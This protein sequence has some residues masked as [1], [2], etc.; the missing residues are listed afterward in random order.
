[1]HRI[2]NDAQLYLQKNS[3]ESPQP[4]HQQQTRRTGDLGLKSNDSLLFI[5]RHGTSEEYNAPRSDLLPSES[6]TESTPTNSPT[7]SMLATEDPESSVKKMCSSFG[8][9]SP[10]LFVSS[11]QQESEEDIEELLR[12]LHTSTNLPFEENTLCLDPDIIDLTIIPPPSDD[13]VD[14]CCVTPD[15]V[16]DRKSFL[17]QETGQRRDFYA[18]ELTDTY[19][20]EPEENGIVFTAEPEAPADSD[21]A[22]NDALSTGEDDLSAYIIPPPPP[23]STR[24]VEEQN[25]VLARFRQAAEEIRRMMAHGNENLAGSKYSDSMNSVSKFCTIPRRHEESHRPTLSSLASLVTPVRETHGAKFDSPESSTSITVQSAEQPTTKDCCVNGSGVVDS[26]T[27]VSWRPQPP[28]RVKR[29]SLVNNELSAGFHGIGSARRHSVISSE[30]SS[31]VSSMHAVKEQTSQNDSS[32]ERVSFGSPE[33]SNDYHSSQLN[34]YQNG[35]DHHPHKAYLYNGYT[36][37]NESNGHDGEFYV[38][39]EYSG[40]ESSEFQ[41]GVSE[42]DVCV[43]GKNGL[44]NGCTCKKINHFMSYHQSLPR[45][46]MNTKLQPVHG[47]PLENGYDSANGKVSFQSAQQEIADMIENLDL[48]C[49]ARLQECSECLP[50]VPPGHSKL[51]KVRDTLIYESRQFVTASKLFVKSIT[52]SSDK[53][54]E[55]LTTCIALLD[56]I[57]A[58]SEL[59]VME[60]TLPSQI[61]SLVE[62]L[63]EMAVAYSRTV[64][65]AHC[66]ASGEIP[67]SNMA[68][69]MHQ[70]TALAT[71]LTVLMRTLR[72][73]NGP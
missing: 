5:P 18:N 59:V 36:E 17:D 9:H 67:N 57:F 64:Q 43:G 72:T 61:N 27:G 24:V 8:L 52:E 62:K 28:P 20:A 71:S 54:E 47:G 68:G 23:S 21:K 46:S 56:R 30:H 14:F 12:Q 51:V 13:D 65:A 45:K 4:Q 42:C 58:V 39:G 73:F 69:L 25:R 11:L 66:A 37:E 33:V 60:M 3:C 15:A 6:E 40:Y 34:G 1:M 31:T 32:D 2:V 26:E 35:H 29:N 16:D 53:M 48:A 38:N 22:A 44:V 10:H 19:Q 63:K 55:H 41:P 7:H 70:A 49:N 50:K